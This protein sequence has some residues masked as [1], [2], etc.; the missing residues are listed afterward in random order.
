MAKIK[1]LTSSTFK[2]LYHLTIS[3]SITNIFPAAVLSLSHPSLPSSSLHLL[4]V[5]RNMLPSGP[6]TCSISC[7]AREQG[8]ERQE[9]R[10]RR[11]KG[12]TERHW[13]WG[14]NPHREKE[15]ERRWER[16][17]GWMKASC[18][19]IWLRLARQRGWWWER[20]DRGAFIF[21][22]FGDTEWLT[23][24]FSSILF[25]FSLLLPSSFTFQISGTN[26]Y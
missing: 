23:Y 17:G 8:G 7:F 22:T 12:R 9:R 21:G 24:F 2:A 10:R 4:V 26:F 18:A 5:R 13:A 15:T 20:G 1:T 16:G 25:D 11:T 3:L 14:G 6:G 19:H